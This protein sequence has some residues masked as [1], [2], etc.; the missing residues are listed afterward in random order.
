MNGFNIANMFI[1]AASRWG[2]RTAMETA[3]SSWTHE[4]YLGLVMQM[5]RH[6]REYGV[7]P[8]DHV[9][10]AL[11]SGPAAVVAMIALWVLGAVAVPL[12]FRSRSAERQRQA[13]SLDIK[14]VVESRNSVAEDA[15]STIKIQDDWVETLG[16]Y[17]R[18]TLMPPPVTHPAILSLTSGTSGA[19]QAMKLDHQ[20]WS[21]RYFIH[22]LEPLYEPGIRFYNPIPI[23]FAASRNQSLTRLL[24]GGTVVFAPPLYSADEIVE[25]IGAKRANITAL[26]PTVL[27]DLLQLA[28]DGKGML[29]P[30][31]DWLHCGGASISGDEK[32][33]VRQHICPNLLVRYGTSGTGNISIQTGSELDRFPDSVGKPHN[34]LLVEI[35]DEENRLLPPGQI[36]AVRVRSPGNIAEIYGDTSQT[37]GNKGDRIANGW[38]YP[39]DLGSLNEEGYLTLHG[40]RSNMIVR[41][42]ANV[43]PAE[44]E[45]VLNA[46][47]AI[48]DS[49]VVGQPSKSL[50]EEI[51]AFVVTNGTVAQS[52]LSAYCINRF[53]ADRRPRDVFIVDSLPKNANGKIMHRQLAASLPL[54]D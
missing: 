45:A 39:G 23:S 50:G 18:D 43:Y 20:T 5:A 38:V 40:R 7:Q 9:G 52:D 35:V 51:V 49:A 42:G 2:P 6:L 14:F 17:S 22:L 48:Q 27:R 28:K 8:G 53:S 1:A 31:L 12:D 15:Y 13:T 30:G 24:S 11:A 32:R 4:Q 36:G 34:I 3:D 29:L 47:P 41:G 54:R 44:L 10:V 33:L 16:G 26:V 46:H 19:Q 21:C 25:A 37:D